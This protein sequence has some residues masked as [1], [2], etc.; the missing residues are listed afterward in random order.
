MRECNFKNRLS[1]RFGA[2]YVDTIACMTLGNRDLNGRGQGD[3]PFKKYLAQTASKIHLKQCFNPTYKESIH[4]IVKM[5]REAA[6]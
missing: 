6:K 2:K 1:T 3:V 5:T 4:W